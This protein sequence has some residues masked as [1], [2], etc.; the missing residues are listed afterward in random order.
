[1]V[2]GLGERGGGFF[3]LCACDCHVVVVVFGGNFGYVAGSSLRGLGFLC[4]RRVPWVTCCLYCAQIRE[5]RPWSCFATA[6]NFVALQKDWCCL[7]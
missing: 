7:E 6:L 1:M 3:T 5:S 2:V 4:L